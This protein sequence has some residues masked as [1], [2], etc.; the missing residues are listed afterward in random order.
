MTKENAKKQ[1]EK[2]VK[3]FDS[4]PEYFKNAKYFD[5]KETRNQFIDPFF[6]AL[7]WNVYNLDP[8]LPESH[9]EV[10]HETDVIVKEK[11][12]KKNKKPDYGFRLNGKELFF[13]DAKKPSVKLKDDTD[14]AF[15]IRR[16]GWS[17]N[18]TIAIVTDFEEFALYETIIE[19]KISDKPNKCLIKYL[20]YKDYINEFDFIWNLFAKENVYKGSIEA[21]SKTEKKGTERI[22][23]KFLNSL[24]NWRKNLAVKIAEE[25]P[26]ISD[27]EL[28][29]I[30]QQTL[31]RIIFLRIA[32]A[33]EIEPYEQLKDC[34]KGANY[35]T[36]LL[37]LYH[38]ANQK[39]NSGLFD[40]KK[41]IIS[42]KTR[43]DNKT[44]SLIIED[45]YFP[46]TSF[47]FDVI[48]VEIIGKAYE[49]F[50]GSII[51]LTK[52][53][54]AKVEKKPTVAKQKGIY[55]TPEYIVD[56]ICK[57]LIGNAI[58][59]KTPKEIEKLK[60]IDP[61]CGSG[62]FLLGAYRTL[63]NY[64]LDYYT[65]IKQKGKQIKELNPNGTL[66]TAVKKKI[67]LNNIYGVDLDENAVEVAKLSL[68]LKCLENENLSS[69]DHQLKLI[70]DRVLPTLDNNIKHGNSLVDPDCDDGLLDFGDNKEFNPFDWKKRF[71]DVFDGGGF[72]IVIG[73]PP[74]VRSK[75]LDSRDREYFVSKYDSAKGTFDIYC[76][77]IERAF[78]IL[79]E[80]GVVGFINQNKYFYS[81]YGD[82]IR[83]VIS[84]K[85]HVDEIVDL[86]EF[87]VFDGITTYT[88]INFFSKRQSKSSF[89]YTCINDKKID[90]R[91]V[92]G[93][94]LRNN[95]NKMISTIKVE[96]KNITDDKWIFKEK[97]DSTF[98]ERVRKESTP[99]I[100]LCYKI[101]QG[102]VLTPTEVFPVSIED[103]Y[104]THYNIKP[105]KQD[106]SIYQIEKHLL[107]PIVKS[108]SIFRYRYE[109]KNYY[110][111]FPY[112]YISDEE[113][114]LITETQLKTKYP[115]AL[116]YFKAKERYLKTREKGKWKN[117]P[118]WYEYSR[119]QNFECQ[120]MNKIIVPGLARKARYTMADE[121]VFIDQG[122]YGIILSEKYK[123]HEKF[124][125]ALLNSNLVDFIF[126]SGAGTLSGGYYSYQSKYLVDLPIKLPDEKHKASKNEIETINGYIDSLIELNAKLYLAQ[127]E[128]QKNQI[129]TKIEYLEEKINK[130]VYE[131][132]N[133]QPQEIISIETSLKAD[134]K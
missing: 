102:F 9:K 129:G 29:F 115:R 59:G 67:L 37:T 60:I 106:N 18:H 112:K 69:I 73:N 62:S 63:L 41:D 111:V 65:S 35:Y 11:G 97:L 98:I 114:E 27:D 86:N 68:L 55:Y 2:L 125:L 72:D 10:I 44:I 22:D 45:L 94:L 108:S 14:P 51:R 118:S 133:I 19:P 99:L 76:I 47:A 90:K 6:K 126:K 123:K 131:L 42:E 122:S 104:K 87:Q 92:E 81:D 38:K 5:E 110:S 49:N 30:V 36:N 71:S 64:H 33:R 91:T 130:Y 83:K 61:A 128:S 96:A 88:A 16:Y 113:V 121:T 100:D 54:V 28:N 43:I 21:Y 57:R 101:Y 58:E 107:V 23:S 48:P 15:Q 89:Q 116:K 132:Y 66:T 24:E 119:K 80:N 53:H 8:V 13:V 32:E 105:I 74:Y 79:K 84:A 95:K 78:H 40:F 124:I 56:F 7:G 39:Y 70:H 75:L 103:E 17:A 4:N 77:F 25:N 12:K 120:K 109:M 117:S 82:G 93:F 26:D 46:N 34:L 134:E 52:G 127:L 50:L 85:Y 31:D 3:T 1:I 20:T